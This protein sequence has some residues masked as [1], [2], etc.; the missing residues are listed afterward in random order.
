MG[1]IVAAA[2]VVGGLLLWV[3]LRSFP[4]RRAEGTSRTTPP[5]IEIAQSRRGDKVTVAD[6]IREVTF[7][8]DRIDRFE[9]GSDKWSR[10]NGSDHGRTVHLELEPGG[11]GRVLLYGDD[12]INIADFRLDDDELARMDDEQSHENVVAGKGRCWR[13]E[14]SREVG[15]FE[16]GNGTGEGF[17]TWRF[18]SEDGD[19]CLRIEKWEN[20]PFAAGVC[21]RVDIDQVTVRRTD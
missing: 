3:V 16:G 5:T 7:T 17:Y 20:E 6:G 1:F 19:E 12:G 10:L 4:P 2:M 14:M 21:R 8:V 18:G 9:T 15:Y 13:Y 11:K